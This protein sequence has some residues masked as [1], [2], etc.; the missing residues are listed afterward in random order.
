[1]RQEPNDTEVK[2]V[3]KPLIESD[4]F[5]QTEQTKQTKQTERLSEYPDENLQQYNLNSAYGWMEC[6]WEE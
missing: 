3:S 2:R 6:K 4:F 1:M 5:T